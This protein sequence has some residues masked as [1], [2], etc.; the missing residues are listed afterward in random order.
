MKLCTSAIHSETYFMGTTKIKEENHHPLVKS[1]LTST[2]ST[3][4]INISINFLEDIKMVETNWKFACTLI[5]IKCI[6]TKIRNT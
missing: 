5:Y 4:I 6:R 3:C 2:T 1:N